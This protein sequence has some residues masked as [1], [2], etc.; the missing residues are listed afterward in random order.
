M[1]SKKLIRLEVKN[2][3]LDALEDLLT[4][5][6][7][8]VE[9]AKATYLA[10]Q[11]WQSLVEAYDKE[12]SND[13]VH[14]LKN[15]IA[16]L[17][18]KVANLKFQKFLDN[19]L[20]KLRG[21][22]MTAVAAD[23]LIN[24]DPIEIHCTD[25]GKGLN[26]DVFLNN[27]L[28]IKS[29]GRLKRIYLK[30]KIKPKEGGE[31]KSVIETN[32]NKAGIEMLLRLIQGNNNHLMRIS[33]SHAINILHYTLSESRVFNLVGIPPTDFPVNL[34]EIKTDSYFNAN[35]YHERLFEFD[36]LNKSH[37]DFSINDAKIAE[38]THYKNSLDITK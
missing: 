21:Q 31:Y 19:E 16:F 27:I 10:K 26:F 8:E 24:P 32:E 11:L 3:Q 1:K 38:I 35:E 18:R 20:L 12:Y 29:S 17:E 37:H 6:L 4:A 22:N 9:K 25:R 5:E 7:D 23:L 13:E 33:K 34:I 28:V 14:I 2:E 15:E 36:Y 30:E